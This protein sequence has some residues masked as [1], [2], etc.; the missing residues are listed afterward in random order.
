MIWQ[1]A[2]LI[3]AVPAA[4]LMCIGAFDWGASTWREHQY[5]R[6]QRKKKEAWK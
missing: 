2:L 6:E 3:V 5:H 1:W 4:L